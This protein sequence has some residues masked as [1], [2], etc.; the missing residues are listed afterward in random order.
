MVAFD[1]GGLAQKISQQ[2]L[3]AGTSLTIEPVS[4]GPLYESKV[5]R[6]ASV[7]AKGTYL[8]TLSGAFG[9]N[10]MLEV[11]VSDIAAVRL[12]DAQIDWVGVYRS[13]R[14]IPESLEKPPLLR[15]RRPLSYRHLPGIYKTRT[16]EFHRLWGRL[17][18][19]RR[20]LLHDRG[21]YCRL[22]CFSGLSERGYDEGDN[23]SHGPFGSS[24]SALGIKG[25]WCPPVI[26]Q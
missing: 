3:V 19:R 9:A 15:S 16:E 8:A 17:C 5:D 4:D 26:G 11:S 10:S 1:R 25:R 12:S 2:L 7:S 13:V 23:Q 14:A 22:C 6:N 21:A 24:S 18:V 20:D